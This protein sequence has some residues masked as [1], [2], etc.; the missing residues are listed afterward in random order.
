MRYEQQRMVLVI[1]RAIIFYST[2]I[3]GSNI[4]RRFCMPDI[5]VKLILAIKPFYRDKRD[6]WDEKD[7]LVYPKT[8]TKVLPRRLAPTIATHSIL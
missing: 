3:N 5:P 8:T 1:L 6:K 7:S 2:L 4:P